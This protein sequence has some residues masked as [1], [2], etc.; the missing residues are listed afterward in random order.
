YPSRTRWLRPKRPMVLH[1][2][3]C[4]RAGGRQVKKEER[5]KSEGSF[6]IMNLKRQPTNARKG[7]AE[8]SG[9]DTGKDEQQLIAAN[10]ISR[11]VLL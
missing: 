11:A 3:R 6:R 8:S 2:R 9:I 1:W 4:G 7:R 5:Q 10:P